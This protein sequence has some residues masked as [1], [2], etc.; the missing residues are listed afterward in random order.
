LA[1]VACDSVGLRLLITLRQVEVSIGFNLGEPIA[2][3]RDVLVAWEV[4]TALQ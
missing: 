3:Y 4:K 1:T 2:C